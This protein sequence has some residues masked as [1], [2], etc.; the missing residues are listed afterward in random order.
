LQV[1]PLLIFAAVG[2]FTPGPNV[3]MSVNM[4]REIGFRR[5]FA[6]IRGMIAGFALIMFLAAMFNIFLTK[7]MPTVRPYLGTVGALYILWLAAKQFTSRKDG[8][9]AIPGQSRPF[10]TGMMLQFI[11]PKVYF[12]GLT[13]MASFILPYYDS[14]SA[15]L[16]F[17]IALGL[18]NMLSL[19]FWACFGVVFQRHFKAHEKILNVVMAALLVY[20]AY[21]VSGIN[22]R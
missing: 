5:A 2:V 7:V 19:S 6:V 9:S 12:Y 20:C 22:L 21:S 1:V 14:I 17:S 4:G 15:A 10:L 18:L 13:I 11:N 3:I 16:L 8:N